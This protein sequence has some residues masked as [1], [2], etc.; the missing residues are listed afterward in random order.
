VKARKQPVSIVGELVR[1]HTRG[2]VPSEGTLD[3]AEKVREYVERMRT[4]TEEQLRKDRQARRDSEA[5]ARTR[6]VD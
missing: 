2:T 5:Q 1:K 6:P 3:T 4:A